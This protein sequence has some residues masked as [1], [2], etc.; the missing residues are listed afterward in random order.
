[1]SI[2]NLDPVVPHVPSTLAPHWQLASQLTRQTLLLLLFSRACPARPLAQLMY[3]FAVDGDLF[4]HHAQD[5]LD[6]WRLAF[7]Q[8]LAQVRHDEGLDWNAEVDLG[9]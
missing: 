4:E 9:L 1:M 2:P 6:A 7:Q 5:E 8:A 3:R